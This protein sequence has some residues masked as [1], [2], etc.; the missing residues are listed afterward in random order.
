MN[1]IINIISSYLVIGKLNIS[2]LIIFNISKEDQL[3][4]RFLVYYNKKIDWTPISSYSF[5]Q[6]WIH[7]HLYNIIINGWLKNVSVDTVNSIITLNP[8]SYLKC[9]LCNI[10]IGFSG[11]NAITVNGIQS[12]WD[13]PVLLV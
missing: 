3:S 7:L 9:Y 11:L 1:S 10:F 13:F 2:N 4:I 6:F 8:P 12:E 5:N